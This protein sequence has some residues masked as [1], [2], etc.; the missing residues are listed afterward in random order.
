MLDV[1]V[2]S[3]VFGFLGN[4]MLLANFTNRI[5]Y[6]IALPASIISWYISTGLVSKGPSD[7]T[8]AFFG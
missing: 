3:L 2:V 1:N 6:I 4:L 8:Y 5:R 7:F